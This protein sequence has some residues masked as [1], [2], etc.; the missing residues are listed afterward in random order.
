MVTFGLIRHARTL[1]NQEK[2][3]QG[4]TQTV[5]SPDGMSD[6]VLWADILKPETYD[7]I[8]SSPM[9]RARQTSQILSELLAVDIFYDADLRE[10]DFG[11]W[12]GRRLTD[13]RKQAPG[14]IERQESRGWAFCP[15]GGESRTRVLKRVSRAMQKALEAFA[16][17]Q[18]L[19]VTHS[20]VMKILIYH[21][22][23]RAFTRDEMPLL[24][25]YHLHELTGKER[26]RIKKL[27]R[28]KLG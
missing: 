19:V 21:L 28:L 16:E 9:T 11:E 8:L 20:S 14:E 26:I 17:N 2:K 25:A 15:P 24:K 6:V 3:I 7:L 23:D 27:N 22:L 10:Q 4:R 5:L 1:W 12:E 18:V 13:I